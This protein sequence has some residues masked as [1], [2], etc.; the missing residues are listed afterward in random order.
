MSATV[1]LLP[2]VLVLAPLIVLWIL[3]VFHILVRR[4]DL[5]V[6]AKALWTVI[7]VLVPYVGL[8][9]YYGLRP[10]RPPQGDGGDDDASGTAIRRLVA[11]ADDHAAGR[12]DGDSFARQK[13]AVFGLAPPSA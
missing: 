6:A 4:R 7:V 10:P 5:S 8:L 11:L 1:D 13:E 3:A 9:L 12:I 2:L